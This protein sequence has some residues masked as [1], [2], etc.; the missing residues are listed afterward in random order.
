MRTVTGHRHQ[1]RR[2][3][4]GRLQRR[5]DADHAVGGVEVCLAKAVDDKDS[6]LKLPG[7]AQGRGRAG[8]GLRADPAQV[9]N[10]GD[11][12]RIKVQQQFLAR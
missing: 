10:Q 11:L 1:A 12:D 9:G 2:L 7:H 5:E 8:A 6:Q 4:D 3:H